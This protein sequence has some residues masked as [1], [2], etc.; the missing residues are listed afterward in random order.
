MT[1]IPVSA[2]SSQVKRIGI[3]LCGLEKA[4]LAALKFLVLQM[5][6]LQRSFEYEFLPTDPTDE[7]IKLLTARSVVNR[8]VVID[9]AIPFT[10]R[11]QRFLENCIADYELQEDPPNYFILLTMARFSDNFYSMNR[12][13]LSVLALGHWQRYM[14][15]PSILEFILTLILRESIAMASPSLR[16][17]IHLG[18]KGCL[19]DFTPSLDEVRYKVLN[20]FICTHC[21]NAFTKDKLPQLA[22]E[23]VYVS[24]KQWLGKA[25]DPTSPANVASKLG[26][27]LFTTKGLEATPLERFMN[28]I[29]EEGVKQIITIIGT[30]VVT[31]L[32]FRLGLKS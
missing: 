15:P 9:K 20:A 18:T 8:K 1:T 13:R 32:L 17:S 21:R 29:R 24:N 30:V 6:S 14:A 12:E 31:I 28:S 5:N 25:S 4:N 7:L 2:P 22:D 10:Q 27:N 26:Y 11:Y 3:M 16:R 19:M 23:L